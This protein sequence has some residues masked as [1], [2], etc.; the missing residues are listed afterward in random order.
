[1]EVLKIAH[2]YT[3]VLDLLER[4]PTNAQWDWCQG[5]TRAVGGRQCCSD[6]EIL[7]LLLQYADGRCPLKD[8]VSV[9]VKVGLNSVMLLQS[10]NNIIEILQHMCPGTIIETYI[11]AKQNLHSGKASYVVLD[12]WVTIEE[13]KISESVFTLRF[14]TT[15]ASSEELLDIWVRF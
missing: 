3:Y 9:F 11:S 5:S 14:E 7:R 12:C 8:K 4:D 6:E 13:M 15:T 1:M 10:C 2:I